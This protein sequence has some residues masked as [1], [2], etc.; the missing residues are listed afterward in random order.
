MQANLRPWIII[1]S[2]TF[3][4]LKKISRILIWLAQSEEQHLART[5]YSV[6]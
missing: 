3:K 1:V 4:E 2:L 5:W 6:R